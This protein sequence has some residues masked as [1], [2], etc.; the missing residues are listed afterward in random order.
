MTQSQS[1]PIGNFENKYESANPIARLLVDGF[2]ASFDQLVASVDPISVL[3]VG[4]GEGMLMRRLEG[5]RATAI[6]GVDI[7]AD[8]FA[9]AQ[10]TLDPARYA[11]EEKSVYDL[12]V[13]QDSADL[14]I[15]CE[16]LEH[17]EEPEKA[18]DRLHALG[19]RRYLFS[20]PREPLW[21]ALNMARLRYVSA[22][23]NTPGHLNHWSQGGF[24]RFISTRFDILASAAPL[25]WT[26][27]LC[28]PK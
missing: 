20:V 22:F 17:L 4:C 11:F 16:V 10:A 25:P 3:E 24:L 1:I 13:Y 14:V 27:V 12:N 8:V 5:T 19:A 7:A 2:L 28:A 23:G 15:C 21:R 18:L 6:K 9:A 26:M